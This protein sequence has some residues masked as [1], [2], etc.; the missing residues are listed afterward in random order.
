M[1]IVFKPKI[2]FG[3]REEV[4]APFVKPSRE[5]QVKWTNRELNQLIGLRAAGVSYVDCAK[6]MKRG[7]SSCTSV[8]VHYDLYEVIAAKRKAFIE[9]VMNYDRAG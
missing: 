6:Y 8:I 1:S 7:H 3:F 9:G 5:P 4:L 2:P